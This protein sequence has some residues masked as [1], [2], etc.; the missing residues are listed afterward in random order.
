MRPEHLDEV[1]AIEKDLFSLPWSRASFLCE[2]SDAKR[3]YSVVGIEDGQVV[4]YAVAWFVADEIHIGNIA[5]RRS[6]QGRGVGKR[7]L[8][9]ILKE[10]KKR[11][12]K[13]ATL[14]VRVSNVR[15]INLYRKFGFEGVAFRKGYYTDNG[16][17]ALVMIAH[18]ESDRSDSVDQDGGEASGT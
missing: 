6:D 5:V 7:L 16:E 2:I 9:H 1:V 18:L 14:E 10:A 3:T 4:C 15:A 11:D 8:S 17:D 12:V 13:L